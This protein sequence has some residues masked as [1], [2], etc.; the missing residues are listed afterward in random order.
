MKRGWVLGDVRIYFFNSNKRLHYTILFLHMS[1]RFLN[2]VNT[3]VETNQL[4][5]SFSGIFIY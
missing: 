5:I 2:Q 3:S 4:L 1:K